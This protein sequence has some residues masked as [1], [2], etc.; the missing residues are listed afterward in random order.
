MWTSTLTITKHSFEPIEP[1]LLVTENKCS[2]LEVDDE[3]SENI[4]HSLKEITEPQ[5]KKLLLCADSR[6]RDVAFNL[7][8]TH[9]RS[10]WFC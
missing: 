2:V 6:G 3:E 10:R 8:K 4:E 7:N 5:L 1:N 9:S